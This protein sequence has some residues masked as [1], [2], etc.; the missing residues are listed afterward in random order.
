MV[1]DT[2]TRPDATTGASRGG[3]FAWALF[4]WANSPFT[5][6]V[7]TFVFPPYFVAAIVGDSTRGQAL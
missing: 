3:R 5:T 6:L 2:D 1:H 4:D 7:I